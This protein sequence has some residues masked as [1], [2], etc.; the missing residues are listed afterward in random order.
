MKNVHKFLMP[1]ALV[2][3]FAAGGKLADFNVVRQ[4][5]TSTS[6]PDPIETS[7]EAMRKGVRLNGHVYLEASPYYSSSTE[8]P[9]LMDYE[10]DL[11][12][13]S[14]GD[15]AYSSYITATINEDEDSAY[16]YEDITYF[17]DEE[18]YTYIDGLSYKNEI[19]RDYLSSTS[20]GLRPF[21]GTGYYNAFRVIQ[22]EDVTYDAESEHFNLDTKKAALIANTLFYHLDAS[23]YGLVTSA[24]FTVGDS[25]MFDTFNIS[26]ADQLYYDAN[27][28]ANYVISNTSSFEL[29]ELGDVSINRLEPVA[30]KDNPDLAMALTSLGDNFTL[31]LDDAQSSSSSPTTTHSY[32]KLYF[33]GTNRQ[34]YIHDYTDASEENTYASTD[35]WLKENEETGMLEIF[36]RPNGEGDWTHITES[37]IGST[38]VS[39][40]PL[41][42]GEYEYEDLLPIVSEVSKD[43]FTWDNTTATYKADSIALDSLLACFYPNSIPSL[44]NTNINSAYDLALALSGTSLQKATFT[45]SK[46]DSGVANYGTVTVSYSNIGST[47]IPTFGE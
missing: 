29:S 34:V 39:M 17:E 7:L 21:D 35:C 36:I 16:T 28:Q 14:D 20:G 46:Y 19:E 10:V 32:T 13:K 30:S 24:Y 22:E 4:A 45:Y 5:D 3:C 37:G 2:A 15:Y 31:V 12:L 9:T 41:Y 1:L 18:G 27:A 8:S 23:F 43:L 38:I 11:A 26:M 47:V 33:D 42:D 25:G 44:R 6:A 40:L